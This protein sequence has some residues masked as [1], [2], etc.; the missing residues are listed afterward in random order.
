MQPPT[1]YDGPPPNPSFRRCG[2]DRCTTH[3]FVEDCYPTRAELGAADCEGSWTKVCLGGKVEERCLPG[4]WQKLMMAMP[5]TKYATCPDG[6][7]A[8][9]DAAA[10][11]P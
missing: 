6:T 9:G 3:R 8:V 7:C 1:N 10:C 2:E 5:A 4:G 11:K